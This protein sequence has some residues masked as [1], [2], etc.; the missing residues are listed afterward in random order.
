MNKSKILKRS[1]AMILSLMMIVA[2]I[3]LSASAATAPKVSTITVDTVE[4]TGSGNAWAASI[5]TTVAGGAFDISIVLDGDRGSV[6]YGGA[7]QTHN[8][9]VWT[10]ALAAGDYAN[11]SSGKLTFQMYDEDAGNATDVTL[12]ISTTNSDTDATIKTFTISGQYGSTVFD[13]TA[14]TVTLTVPYGYEGTAN[15][16]PVITTNSSKIRIDEVATTFNCTVNGTAKAPARDNYIAVAATDGNSGTITIVS[17]A[18]SSKTYTVYVKSAEGFKTF[19]VAGQRKDANIDTD[20][21]VVTVYMPY[22]TNASTSAK[23]AITPTFTTGY[24][25]VKV[26]SA[27]ADANLT[28]GKEIEL[29]SYTTK[30]LKA[31][32]AIDK[33]VDDGDTEVAL[34]LLYTGGAFEDW[35]VEF[36]V[37]DGDPVAEI[38]SF[39]VGA[40]AATISGTTITLELPASYRKAD[41]TAKV[42]VS[43]NVTVQVSGSATVNTGAADDAGIAAMA[44]DLTKN[45]QTLLVKAAANDDDG[46]LDAKTYTLNISTKEAEQ[47]QLKAISLQD[48]DGN[49]YNASINQTTGV[50]AFT[51]VPFAIKGQTELLAAGYKLFYTLSNGSEIVELQ[52][53]A[54]NSAFANPTGSTLTA[55]GNDVFPTSFNGGANADGK[56]ESFTV[57]TVDADGEPLS[58]KAYYITVARANAARGST[59]T[60]FTISTVDDYDDL[61]TSNSITVK[62]TSAKAVTINVAN[63]KYAAY[64][65]NQG[66]NTYA[67]ATLSDEAKLYYVDTADGDKL[68][69]ITL[70]DEDTDGVALP[71]ITGYNGL[72]TTDPA[73]LT[74][75]VLSEQ[76]Q[77]ILETPVGYVWGA[78]AKMNIQGNG[79]NA[80]DYTEYKLSIVQKAA[81][82]GAAIQSFSI[83]NIVLD[84]TVKATINTS[85]R[86]ISATIPYGWI[87]MP[88]VTSFTTYQDSLVKME[89]AAGNAFATMEFDSDG[90]WDTVSGTGIIVANSDGDILAD[91]DEDGDVDDDLTTLWAVS[92]SEVNKNNYTLNFTVAEAKT[93]AAMTSATINN[94]TGRPDANNKV[95]ITLPFATEITALKIKFAVS[96]NAF[97]ESPLGGLHD[98]DTAYNFTTPQVFNVY[99]EDGN[100][101]TAYT[102]A[103]VVSDEFIDVPSTAWYYEEVMEAAAAGIVLGDGQ[104][105]FLPNG[106]VTRGQFAQFLARADGY[107]ADEYKDI[108]R[109]TDVTAGTEQAAAITYCYDKGYISGAG[110]NTFNPNGYINREQIAVILA[111][112][113]GLS[114]VQSGY[115]PVADDAQISSWA[116]GYV[117]A[118]LANGTMVGTGSGFNPKGNATRAEAAAVCVRVTK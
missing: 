111:R 13:H 17:E 20:N 60:D 81:Q 21:K 40:F 48:T 108:T 112:F 110:D 30:A 67:Q 8:N 103:V 27:K 72:P 47:A 19:S 49:T 105:H 41:G 95:T 3:P 76:A 10:I 87:G 98:D 85:T 16:V 100:N 52:D 59:L 102:V 97:V 51:G 65:K 61:T 92:E 84:K 42:G 45:T 89:T 68:K 91:V 14:N 23:Y 54:D 73:T 57:Y 33:D 9:G 96:E 58:Y 18:G 12:T 46:N 39:S 44:V 106:L 24:P 15:N 69:A 88:L 2:M 99:S 93:G 80:N 4:A 109:F 115:E 5:S 70:I 62:P 66:G 53:P 29:S 35:T 64:D 22:G 104:G 78:A 101:M 50:V 6:W 77:A 79:G 56:G 7:Q 117:Y 114:Q 74:L 43:T 75:V 118:V 71:D 31:S 25:S 86:V 94:V 55:D 82:D 11:L 26:Y 90:D 63:S 28:S 34:R 38:K 32:T 107:T 37:P 1:L 113:L 36:D 116:K 83:Y